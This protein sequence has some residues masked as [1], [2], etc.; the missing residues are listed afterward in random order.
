MAR[1]ALGYELGRGVAAGLSSADRPKTS[2]P[3]GEGFERPARV[4]VRHW[5]GYKV[6]NQW[7]SSARRRGDNLPLLGR[8]RQSVF[9]LYKNKTVVEYQ[10]TWPKWTAQ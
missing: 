5:V 2:V 10:H 1:Q 9:G 6:G 8:V 3:Q 7:F 4:A